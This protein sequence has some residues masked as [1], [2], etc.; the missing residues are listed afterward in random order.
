M[1][2]TIP[3]DVRPGIV[4]VGLVSVINANGSSWLTRCLV[5]YT[6]ADAAAVA[7]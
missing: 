3:A 6:N 5:G 4:T 1:S 7:T 2:T